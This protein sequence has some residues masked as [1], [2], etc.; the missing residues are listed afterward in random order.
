MSLLEKLSAKQGTP[1]GQAAAV[2]ARMQDDQRDPD[3]VIL[4]MDQI[5]VDEQARKDL[6]DLESMAASIKEHGQMNAVVVVPTANLYKFKLHKGARRYFSMRDILHLDTIR[7]TIDRSGVHNDK[8]KTRLGQ[9]HEN[10]QR[11]DYEPFE[12]ANEFQS[13]IDETG[14]THEQLAEKVGVSRGWVTKKLSLLKAPPE[15][16]A[17]IRS[18]ELAETDYYNDK[19][20]TVA[21]KRE[22][23]EGGESGTGSDKPKKLSLPWDDAISLAG[24]VVDLAKRAGV[25]DLDISPEP[26]KKELLAILA[27]VGDV[28]SAA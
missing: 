18:G 3:A 10:I 5:E 14:W 8:V 21:T 1:S 22:K 26:D 2:A 6:G 15:I 25:R 20:G 12:L 4:T 23:P 24:L 28:R 27:R 13:L 17:A 16:Q 19:A 7:A 9:L 11:K